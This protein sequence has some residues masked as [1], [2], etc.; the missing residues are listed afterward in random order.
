MPQVK[1]LLAVSDIDELLTQ[2]E[3]QPVFIFKHSTTCPISARAHRQ[4][5]EYLTTPE[6]SQGV[7]HALVRVIE[8]RPVSL[9]LAQRV[10]VQH[11]SPQ[12]ILLRNRKAVWHDSHRALT[13]DAMQDALK[14]S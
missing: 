1:Q 14:K 4:F 12:M 2:S 3:S 13:V 8:E 11:E 7:A 10:G 5:E 9:E 6:A